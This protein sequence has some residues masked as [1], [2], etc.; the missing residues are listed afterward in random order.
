MI[1]IPKQNNSQ[2]FLRFLASE[3]FSSFLSEPFHASTLTYKQ[4]INIL[5]FF[6]YVKAVEPLNTFETIV[7]LLKVNR[8]ACGIA[9]NFQKFTI[10]STV[11]HSIFLLYHFICLFRTYCASYSIISDCGIE[12]TNNNNCFKP[13]FMPELQKAT[14]I[15]SLCHKCWPN[16]L[17]VPCSSPCCCCC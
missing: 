1:R 16:V 9:A 8:F 6:S 4:S 2:S 3:K 10:S 17:V 13:F 12:L 11:S 5:S 15:M 14:S 7:T